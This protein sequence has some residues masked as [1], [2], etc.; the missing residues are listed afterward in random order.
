MKIKENENFAKANMK[1]VVK[2]KV[3]LLFRLMWYCINK[4]LDILMEWV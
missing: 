1:D 2:F 4:P 3:K